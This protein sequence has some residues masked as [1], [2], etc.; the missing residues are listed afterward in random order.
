M[1]RQPTADN[2]LTRASCRT[3]STLAGR[4]MEGAR[5]HLK[6]EARQM[7]TW[8]CHKPGCTFKRSGKTTLVAAARDAHQEVHRH[9]LDLMNLGLAAMGHPKLGA[10]AWW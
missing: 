10:A 1:A 2:D 6:Q 5:S 3:T 8:K 7:T 4:R 9:D